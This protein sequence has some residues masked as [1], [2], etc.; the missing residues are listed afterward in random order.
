MPLLPVPV[1]RAGR[2]HG[3]ICGSLTEELGGPGQGL[4]LPRATAPGRYVGLSWRGE[5]GGRFRESPWAQGGS[6]GEKEG[7]PQGGSAGSLQLVSHD[8]SEFPAAARTGEGP[9]SVEASSPDGLTG[10]PSRVGRA[11]PCGWLQAQPLPCLLQLPAVPRSMACA[12]SSSS[13][14][15][16]TWHQVP[17]ASCHCPSLLPPFSTL[18]AI[19]R[20]HPVIQTTSHPRS[21]MATFTPLAMSPD[22]H[23]VQGLECGRLWGHCFASYLHQVPAGTPALHWDPARS[24]SPGA[25]QTTVAIGRG[26]D[27][28]HGPQ[29][30]GQGEG[31]LSRVPMAAPVP[32]GGGSSP[33]SISS[34]ERL[35]TA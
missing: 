30:S 5:V 12:P 28:A 17:L 4:G 16:D 23:R 3:P 2:A 18:S 15:W 14:P 13:K 35:P 31:A 29:R 25:W 21:A 32:L 6:P 10:L 33:A 27:P 34:P 26:R 8:S 22:S 19:T 20:A 1:L 7:H 24:A 9:C 11:E